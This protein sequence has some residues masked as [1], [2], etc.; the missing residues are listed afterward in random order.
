MTSRSEF[1]PVLVIGGRGFVGS[2]LVRALVAHGERPHVFGPAMS[3]DLLAGLARAFEETEGSVEDRAVIAEAIARSGAR[4]LVTTAAYSAGRQ[5]LM[6]SGDAETERA[7]AVNVLG[8]RNV[9]EAA[10]E[11]GIRRVVWTGSTVVYGPAERYGAAP[12]DEDAP[13]GPVTVYG[14]TKLLS[15]TIARYYRDRHQLDVICLRLPL[16]LGPGLWYQGAAS[17]I[18][19]IMTD[20]G[21]GKRHAVS[22]HDEPMDLM[23]VGDVARALVETLRHEGALEPVYNVNGFTARMSEIARAAERAVPGYAVEL[24]PVPPA[25]TFPLIDDGRFRA[26]LGFAPEYGLEDVVAAML[27]QETVR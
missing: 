7:F 5:G 10:R 19:G 25:L 23:H 14:L 17:S 4:T 9:L 22:F 16:V 11:A 18:V 1:E 26:A 3:D 15:E 24:A 2:H 21:P 6:R 12:V 8:F 27:P 13:T 20:A